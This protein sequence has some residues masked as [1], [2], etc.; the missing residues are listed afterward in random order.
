VLLLL[1][2]ITPGDI[3]RQGDTLVTFLWLAVPSR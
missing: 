2:V 3:T 1:D